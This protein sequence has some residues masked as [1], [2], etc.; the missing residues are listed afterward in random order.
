MA[1]KTHIEWTDATWNP[2]TGCTIVSPGCTH[3]YAMK[4]AG[5]RLKHHPSRAG[6]TT[7][8]KSGPVWNGTVRFNAGWLLQPISWKKPRNIFVCAHGDLFHE[9]VPDEWIDQV[10]A[11]M[12]MSPQH[13]FQVLTK[14][15]ARMRTYLA[16]FGSNRIDNERMYQIDRQVD[17]LCADAGRARFE[18][19]CWPLPNVWLGVSTERQK[20]ADERIPDLLQTPAAVRFISA[21]PLLG[22]IDIDCPDI[23]WMKYPEGNGLVGDRLKIDWVIVGGESGDQARP[24]HPEWARALRDQCANAAIAFFFKQHGNWAPSTPDA[25]FGNPRS[26]WMALSGKSPAPV[27]ELYPDAGAAFVERMTKE[28]AGRLLDGVEH[29]GMPGAAA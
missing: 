12:A 10:F 15:S 29:N 24:M 9:D 19:S 21:E 17:L 22:P 11:V 3:C 28:R 4:L 13:T 16:A 25:A 18:A 6:L 7:M 1:D 26:G 27:A 2:I 20:E 5:T 23:D 8:S 14:R